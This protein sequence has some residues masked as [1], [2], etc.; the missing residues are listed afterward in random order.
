LKKELNKMMLPV[1]SI[2]QTR[3][4]FQKLFK[5]AILT[6]REFLAENA[7]ETSTDETVSIIRTKLLDEWLDHAYT[8]KPI[9]ELDEE[10]RL[11]SVTLPEIRIYTDAPTREEAT[12]Q[13]VELVLDYCEDYFNRLD[14]FTA[15]PDRHGHYPYLRRI[16]RCKGTSEVKEVL[17]L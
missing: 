9:W 7:K 16:I 11:W 10:N 2:S 3:T 12:E 14:L 1:N 4:E 15:L 13:V 8:F 17:N 6:N 5:Q